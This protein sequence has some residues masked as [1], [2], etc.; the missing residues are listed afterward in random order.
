L[1]ALCGH[2]KRIVRIGPN[3]VSHMRSQHR[4]D[5]GRQSRGSR[6]LWDGCL[7]AQDRIT[8]TRDPG[9]AGRG[10]RGRGWEKG[11]SP[12]LCGPGF[13]GGSGRP[14]RVQ[15]YRSPAADPLLTCT[16]STKFMDNCQ[17][18]FS[19]QP[20]RHDPDEFR[21]AIVRRLPD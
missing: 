21:G 5:R 17:P 14:C 6:I 18:C 13:Q 10:L 4:C 8:Q 20:H 15:L 19:S 16:K 1:A 11:L 12:E 7:G 9:F 3:A 2:K